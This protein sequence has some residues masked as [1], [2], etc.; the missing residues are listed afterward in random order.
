M[1]QS[2]APTEL[3]F[4]LGAPGG[5]DGRIP[6][7]RPGVGGTKNQTRIPPTHPGRTLDLRLAD[8][9][10]EAAWATVGP[11][12]PAAIRPNPRCCS[13]ADCR[14]TAAAAHNGQDFRFSRDLAVVQQSVCLPSSSRCGPWRAGWTGERLAKQSGGIADGRFSRE[15]IQ[16]VSRLA[17]PTS[18]VTGA[19]SSRS[20]KP[21]GVF[22]SKSLELAAAGD[23]TDTNL[24][25]ST[26]YRWGRG[27]SGHA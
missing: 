16:K 7:V 23:P 25:D 21:S 2:R 14:P 19:T 20:T 12:T 15:A 5:A 27:S 26:S 4:W 24:L 18:I 13:Y 11:P 22:S 1:A 17:Q 6:C 8:N 9:H 3:R 10:V